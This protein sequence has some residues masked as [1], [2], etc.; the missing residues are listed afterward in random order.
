MIKKIIVLIWLALLVFLSYGKSLGL[1][2]YGDD[3][4]TISKYFGDYGPHGKRGGYLDKSVVFSNY[5]PQFLTMGLAYSLFKD[6]PQP[7][8]YTSLILRTLLAFSLFWFCKKLM[9][10]KVG[11]LASSLF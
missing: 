9:N 4:L 2:L 11:L 5:G 10:A 1:S 3:W 6:D 8:F 7:Y